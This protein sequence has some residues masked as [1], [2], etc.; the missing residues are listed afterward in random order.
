MGGNYTLE[1]YL[2]KLN[3]HN[4]YY[5]FNEHVLKWLKYYNI[6]HKKTIYW[7]HIM[8]IKGFIVNIDHGLNGNK[9]MKPNT[10]IPHH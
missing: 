4:I 2:M 3:S 1:K 5:L 10:C 9:F 7:K 8:I 6:I